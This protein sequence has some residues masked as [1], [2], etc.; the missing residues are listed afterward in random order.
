VEA[1]DPGSE[2]VVPARQ[3]ANAANSRKSTGPIT[4]AGKHRSSQNSLVHGVYARA[5]AIES[6]RFAED[7]D[8]MQQLRAAIIEAAEPADPLEGI[9]AQLYADSLIQGLGLNRFAAAAY[10]DAGALLLDSVMTNASLHAAERVTD[11]DARVG[12]RQ[13][14]LLRQLEKLH[15]RSNPLQDPDTRSG[16]TGPPG[17]PAP[18]T[19][20]RNEPQ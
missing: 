13:Q 9:V 3:R 20:P 6:G 5:Q 18:D 1:E 15:S 14:Q 16:S 12:R 10:S 17:P 19:E 8:E 2:S 4:A 7:P 11:I